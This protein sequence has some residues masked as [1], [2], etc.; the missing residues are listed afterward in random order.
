VAANYL[1]TQ[2][3]TVIVNATRAAVIATMSGVLSGAGTYTGNIQAGSLQLGHHLGLRNVAS[4]CKWPLPDT[5]SVRAI[6]VPSHILLGSCAI[7]SRGFVP[8]HFP[9]ILI[10]SASRAGGVTFRNTTLP[11]RSSPSTVVL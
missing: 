9:S 1:N 8:A 6:P 10:T 5:P 3:G 2:T 4:L 7:P 11:S